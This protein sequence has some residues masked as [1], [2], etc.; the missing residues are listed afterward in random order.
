M[1][2]SNTEKTTTLETEPKIEG[3]DFAELEAIKRDL[4]ERIK[5]TGIMQRLFVGRVM[6]HSIKDGIELAN[7]VGYSSEEVIRNLFSTNKANSV[8]LKHKS[9]LVNLK[10]KIIDYRFF[11][12]KENYKFFVDEV[13]P[14]W[15]SSDGYDPESEILRQEEKERSGD[16][17][18]LLSDIDEYYS[19][20]LS[21]R[22]FIKEDSLGKGR[23]VKIEKQKQTEEE[24]VDDAEKSGERVLEW[25][26]KSYE[27]NYETR[28]VKPLIWSHLISA[29]E[30]DIDVLEKE[31]KKAGVADE[32]IAKLIYTPLVDFATLE[33]IADKIG[34]DLESP[35]I[36]KK[37]EKFRWKPYQVAVRG[38]DRTF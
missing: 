10:E 3:K 14:S 31:L 20:F 18:E 2:F 34:L 36:S 35:D 11:L 5:K 25:L 38:G 32:D 17:G 27:K 23:Q 1:P 26:Q 4:F 21:L 22:T 16:S 24:K 6:E 7:F 30:F 9:F 33:N 28:M 8:A 19:R 12:N 13:K 37:L 29:G 15:F